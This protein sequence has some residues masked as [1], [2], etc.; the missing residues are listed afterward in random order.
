MSKIIRN[1]IASVDFCDEDETSNHVSECSKIVQK[2]YK[3]K[4][5]RVGRVIHRELCK[6][7][8]FD[9]TIKYYVHKPK[10]GYA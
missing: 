9:H 8:K 6:K 2:E 3:T 10:K 7:L 5:D 4:H 1:R